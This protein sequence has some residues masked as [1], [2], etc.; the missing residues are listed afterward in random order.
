MRSSTSRNRKA[1]RQ[2]TNL[3]INRDLLNAARESGVNLS[4]V[5]EEAL[6]EKVAAARREKWIRENAEA[7]ERYNDLVGEQGVFS[8]DRRSF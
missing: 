7:I 6:E 4:A 1:P 2:A 5:L 3:S 8:D